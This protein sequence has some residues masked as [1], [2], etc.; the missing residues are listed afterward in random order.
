MKL[1]PCRRA[2]KKKQITK[3]HTV[4]FAMIFPAQGRMIMNPNPNR[5][6]INHGAPTSISCVMRYVAIDS[7]PPRVEQAGYRGL[8]IS[9][10]RHG[11]YFASEL[12]GRGV[13][14]A[15]AVNVST[16]G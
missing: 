14:R 12:G 7:S 5:D 9:G 10:T 3:M 13:V 1:T 2:R 8:R 11:Q 15:Q 4:A 16:G 6:D